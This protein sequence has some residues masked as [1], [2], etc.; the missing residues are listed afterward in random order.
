MSIMGRTIEICENSSRG[1]AG[2][3]VIAPQCYG[4]EATH[5]V[6]VIYS[7]DHSGCGADEDVLRLCLP[8]TKRVKKD[9]RKH[10]YAVKVKRIR[11]EKGERVACD[12]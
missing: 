12:E 7:E 8:C 9:A 2:L 1:T 11:T 3:A 10:G 4:S 5:E 6:K